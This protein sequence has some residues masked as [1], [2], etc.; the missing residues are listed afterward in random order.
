M[1]ACVTATGVAQLIF[2]DSVYTLTLRRRGVRV[3]T[4]MDLSILRRI[5][6]EQ[7]KLDPVTTVPQSEPFERLLQLTSNN[8]I[9]DFIVVDEAGNYSG[10]VVGEDVKTAL[11]EREA[12]P[13]LLAG[14]VVREDLPCLN[15]TDDLA[16][17]VRPFLA[18][19]LHRLPVCLVANPDRVI[20]LLVEES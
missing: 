3:G 7:V 20:G 14:D 16:T 18:T 9:S 1:L 2:T 10:I 6:I 17:A 12:I 5:T 15:N 8:G 13:L 11:I 19:K 4:G